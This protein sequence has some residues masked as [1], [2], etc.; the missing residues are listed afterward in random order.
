MCNPR[1]DLALPE[2]DSHSDD[3]HSDDLHS[4][5]LHFDDVAWLNR[6]INFIE[7]FRNHNRDV[8]ANVILSFL[9]IARYPGITS[10]E[11]LRRLGLN[12]QGAARTVAILSKYGDRG[13][14]GWDVVEYMEDPNDRRQKPLMLN[15][16]GRRLFDRLRKAMNPTRA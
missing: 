1:G 16:R 10:K 2:G 12:Q 7:E 6:T 14:E 3:L 11:L 13:S 15:A 4:D 8:T 9:L 5:D